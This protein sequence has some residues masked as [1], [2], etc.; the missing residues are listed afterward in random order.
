MNTVQ[1]P[2]ARVSLDT[3]EDDWF[4]LSFQLELG[5]TTLNLYQGWSVEDVRAWMKKQG[6]CVDWASFPYSEGVTVSKQGQYLLVT[7]DVGGRESD[8]TVNCTVM[9]HEA[10]LLEVL[11]EAVAEE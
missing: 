6:A 7:G 10:D 3:V 9:V 8:A 2:V 1:T 5:L 11:K 4:A